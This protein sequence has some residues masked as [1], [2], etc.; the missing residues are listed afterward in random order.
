MPI[1]LPMTHRTSVGETAIV[2]IDFT[3]RLAGASLTGTPTVVEQTTSDLT[4]TDVENNDGTYVSAETGATVATNK[5][6]WCR[7]TSATTGT[8]SLLVT[9]N[10][11]ATNPGAETLKRLIKLIV[12]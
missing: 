8:Y 4:I 7:I 1:T 6:V 11:D 5:A 10:T 2:P 9:A 12:E 3:D